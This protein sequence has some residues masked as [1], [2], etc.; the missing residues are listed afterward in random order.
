MYVRTRERSGRGLD[1]YTA[2]LSSSYIGDAAPSA[3]MECPARYEKGEVETSRCQ[4]GAC[5]QG[6]LRVDVMS[7]PRG[8]LIADFGVGQSGIKESTKKE[9]LL[10]DWLRAARSDLHSI[11]LHI[12]GYSD[13]VGTDEKN[14]AL[15]RER[16]QRVRAL[17]GRN[18]QSRVEFVG[19]AP[20][21]EYVADNKTIEG[22][23]KNRGVIIELRRLPEQII[24]VTGR[25]PVPPKPPEKRITGGRPPVRPKPPTLPPEPSLPSK[26][27]TWPW[28][29]PGVITTS[30]PS[31]SWVWQSMSLAAAALG[32]V[33]TIGV[34]RLTQIELAT[35][36]EAA[37]LVFQLESGTLTLRGIIGLAA[38]AA[39]GAIL[40]RAIGTD[41]AK[42]FNLN[43]IKGGV[44]G[45]SFP[46]LDYIA[47]SGMF[48]VKVKGIFGLIR[49]GVTL[50]REALFAYTQDLIDLA[51]GGPGKNRKL[52]DAAGLLWDNR[53]ML[54]R[55]GAWPSDLKPRNAADVREY[56]VNKSYLMVPNDHLQPLKRHIGAELAARLRQLNVGRPVGVTQAAWINTFVDRVLPLGVT[57][58]DL[59][60]MVKTARDHLPPSQVERLRKEH[61]A[62]L[63]RGRRRVR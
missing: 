29:P 53:S 56:L 36:I 61:D 38:E 39:A 48:S 22:R 54:Q 44:R 25:V 41:A 1:P 2:G 42:I 35:A 7:H 23:A 46:V 10:H 55:R 47:S 62:L 11:F 43:L 18:L 32:A 30:P 16:A 60:V 40:P 6:H 9:K 31:G 45:G 33:V 37:W 58:S 3:K 34:R 12:Y 20:A 52:D 4:K 5:Q 8:L 57:T 49:G 50:D 17:L 27:Q 63:R 51:I 28:R 14:V 24:E 26:Y 15:R 59:Q 21:G 13:C 19:P